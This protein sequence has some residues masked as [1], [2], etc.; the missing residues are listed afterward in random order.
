MFYYKDV[1]E[2]QYLSENTNLKVFWN[3]YG[4]YIEI[5]GV[6]LSLVVSIFVFTRNLSKKRK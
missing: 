5:A 6:C 2:Q 4:L 1:C 3:N